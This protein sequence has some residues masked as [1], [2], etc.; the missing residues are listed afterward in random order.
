MGFQ[1][2]GIWG[3]V[4]QYDR[5]PDMCESL[6][7][8]GQPNPEEAQANLGNWWWSGILGMWPRVQV[9]RS[10]PR[11]KMKKG[12]ILWNCGW[13]KSGTAMVETCWNPS[14][15]TNNGVGPYQTYQPPVS[16]CQ[17]LD[18]TA[19][20]MAA[21]SRRKAKG[22]KVGNLKGW[23]SIDAFWFAIKSGVFSK[24]GKPMEAPNH[25]KFVHFSIE[26]GKA[27]ISFET[28]WASHTEVLIN[29]DTDR[30]QI[31]S[32]HFGTTQLVDILTCLTSSHIQLGVIPFM[33]IYEWANGQAIGPC[34]D[35]VVDCLTLNCLVDI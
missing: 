6:G 33:N 14:C 9:P 4:L 35:G 30:G 8:L 15:P 17:A 25:V 23:A 24:S 11:K 2:F 1:L 5:K 31:W 10:K 16:A 22:S 27:M 21:G 26:I 29:V 13:K 3:L 19:V 28:P 20:A 34:D 18:K 32:N 12:M 7:S